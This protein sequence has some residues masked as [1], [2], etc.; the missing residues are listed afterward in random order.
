MTARG[1]GGVVI[2]MMDGEGG[3]EIEGEV[4]VRIGEVE[5]IVVR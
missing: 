5:R 3:D 1:R 4:E 2:R